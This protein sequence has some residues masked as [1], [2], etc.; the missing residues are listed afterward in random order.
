M[1]LFVCAVDTGVDEGEPV[2]EFA[3]QYCETEHEGQY[4]EQEFPEGFGNGKFN[5]IL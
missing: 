3:E 1:C 4:C 2:E 5:L